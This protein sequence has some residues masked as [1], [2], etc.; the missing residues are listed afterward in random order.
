MKPRQC[1]LIFFLFLLYLDARSLVA[2]CNKKW[3]K[4]SALCFILK[5][6]LR[7]WILARFM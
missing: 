6:V 2:T 4:N 1:L 5:C 3:I 7:D